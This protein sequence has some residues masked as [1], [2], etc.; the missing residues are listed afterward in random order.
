MN[1]SPPEQPPPNGALAGSGVPD[2][3]RGPATP[4]G[5]EPAEPELAPPS[6]EPTDFELDPAKPVGYAW[7]L[8]FI[9]LLSLLAHGSTLSIVGASLKQISEDLDTTETFL[10]WT[11]TG[12][13]LAQAIGTT[14]AGKLG[15]L[16][17]HRNIYLVG[18]ALFVAGLFSSG[19]A[20]DATSLIAFRIVSGLG[21]SM[22]IPT[23]M[24]MI[25]MAFP[26]YLRPRALGWFHAV[27]TGAPALG[28]AVGGSLVD[29][30]GWEAVFFLYGPFA[31]TGAIFAYFTF[32]STPRQENVSVDYI[33]SALLAVAAAGLLLGIDRGAIL[34]FG[35]GLALTMLGA[36][37][38]GLALF[39]ASQMKF[40]Q[41]RRLLP[42]SDK[43]AGKQAQPL[44]P[45]KYFRLPSY[46]GSVITIAL[47]NFVYM[48]GFVI[49][50]L[51]LQEYFGI[52]LAVVTLLLLIRPATFSLSSPFGGLLAKKPGER[53]TAILG[54]S[55]M[56]VSMLA[57]AGSG[58]RDYVWLVV[59]GLALSGACFGLV[60]P[61]LQLVITHTIPPEDLGVAMGVT[62]TL[63]S[64]AVASGIQT[65][66]LVLGDGRS[67]GDFST[68]Y[69][70]GC[71]VAVAAVLTA[72]IVRS[73]N[74]T[75]SAAKPTGQLVN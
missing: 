56:V 8:L 48:G 28:L 14:I 74:V 63:A 7:K 57:F 67:P 16:Y 15:D 32:R 3:K 21:G 13:F 73:T 44:V 68:A 18:S 42:G 29:L 71:G 24:A 37:L 65:L 17:G 27:A 39:V 46:T 53:F 66:L 36:G 26:I 23:G 69:L 31:L 2:P 33:G 9:V 43:A 62:Q 58:H 22:M 49:T 45:L 47:T 51:L 12:P 4:A 6:Y 60:M 59:V 34:G 54:S 70:V 61:S 50:P 72:S 5:S 20:W 19:L 40:H 35:S 41:L 38:L 55:C 64:I 11:L 1:G 10:A 75:Y 30:L 52:Q 25:M